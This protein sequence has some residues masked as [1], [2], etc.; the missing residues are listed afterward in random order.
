MLSYARKILQRYEKI[1]CLVVKQGKKKKEA[2]RMKAC[3]QIIQ[4][5]KIVMNTWNRTI[6]ARYFAIWEPGKAPWCPELKMIRVDLTEWVVL[7]IIFFF[8][9][10]YAKIMR[11][12]M[13]KMRCTMFKIDEPR[14]SIIINWKCSIEIESIIYVFNNFLEK[15][16]LYF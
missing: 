8:F 13:R 1:T 7:K 12:A 16:I 9:F 6:E 11:S 10:F 5:W 15:I 2:R 4:G 14:R 3:K